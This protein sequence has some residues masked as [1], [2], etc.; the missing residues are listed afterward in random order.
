V[1]TNVIPAT[2]PNSA[3]ICRSPSLL[4]GSAKKVV[5]QS[6]V[7]SNVPFGGG[8]NLKKFQPKDI[9]FGGISAIIE[10]NKGPLVTIYAK[11]TA[12]K[13]KHQLNDEYLRA[14]KDN[15][16]EIVQIGNACAFL[17]KKIAK[18]AA[19]A[20]STSAISETVPVAAGKRT[21]TNSTT[22]RSL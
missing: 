15:K 4:G 1:G 20:K 11:M 17:P 21:R 5:G 14:K 9:K 22:K 16:D 12:M 19:T 6:L 13:L 7:T 3:V 2:P 18:P 8:Q 10:M